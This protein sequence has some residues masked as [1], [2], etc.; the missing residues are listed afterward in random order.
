MDG[1]LRR[2]PETMMER[3]KSGFS[4]TRME[5]QAFLVPFWATEKRDSPGKAKQKPSAKLGNRLGQNL[6]ATLNADRAL[7]IAQATAA[8]SC[9]LHERP[10]CA[11]SQSLDSAGLAPDAFLARRLQWI[12]G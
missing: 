6:L 1:P 11:Y 7:Q 5:G 9:V 2:A 12:A 3:G 10:R 8:S 4:Q